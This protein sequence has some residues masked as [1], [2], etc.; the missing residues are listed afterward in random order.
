[1]GCGWYDVISV[2]AARSQAQLDD[3]TL[4][5]VC[6][7]ADGGVFVVTVPLGTIGG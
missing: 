7:S 4:A 1:L 3:E 5:T 2:R 6:L